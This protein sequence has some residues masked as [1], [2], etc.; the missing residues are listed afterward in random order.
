MITATIVTPDSK[1]AK[2]EY[3]DVPAFAKALTDLVNTG[4]QI[5]VRCPDDETFMGVSGA[6]ALSEQ[7]AARS[8]QLLTGSR[9][10]FWRAAS[11]FPDG[12][13]WRLLLVGLTANSHPQ[14]SNGIRRPG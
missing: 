11:F 13:G 9:A 3:D 5:I 7:S 1:L 10:A 12:D 4:G 2:R 14:P 8:T 6:C